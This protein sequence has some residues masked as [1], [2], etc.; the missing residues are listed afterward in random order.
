VLRGGQRV[1]VTQEGS[2]NAST[3]GAGRGGNI[4]LEAP[5]VETLNGARVGSVAQ[6]SGAGGNISII[7]PDAFIATGTNGIAD[8]AQNRGSRITAASFFTSTANAGSI[9][10]QAG[11]VELADGA[12]LSSSTSGIGGGGSVSIV[13][14]GPVSLVGARGD[15][16]GSAIKASTEVEADEAGQVTGPRLG[17]AGAITIQAPQLVL[18]DRAEIV[19]NTALAGAGGRIVINVGSLSLENARI[20]SESTASGANAGTA[21]AVEI[22]ATDGVG[23]H[24]SGR[25]SATTVDGEGGSIVL[26]ANRIYIQGG[27]IS[28]ASTGS[29]NAGDVRVTA[30]DEL[31]MTDGALRTSAP[32]SAGGDIEVMVQ[33]RLLMTDSSITAEAGGVTATD[34]GGNIAIDPEYVIM[35]S[36]DLIA[37]A[38][39]GN[40]GNITIQAG[41]FIP[42][43]DSTIDA[44][45]TSGFDGEVLIDSPNEI[46]GSVLPLESPEVVGAVV[47]QSCVPRATEQRSTLTVETRRSAAVAPGDYLPSPAPEGQLAAANALP[48]C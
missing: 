30:D 31:V 28:A 4:T 17:N 39:A 10:V 40:G 15:G 46:L 19:G 16:A 27:E 5:V 21:G 33:R 23:L 9:S 29:G 13:A 7:A 18:A 34:S 12:R 26:H 44:S 14:T 8:P 25:I 2:V 41:F 38:N 35:T 20:A 48:A 24:D 11:R 3:S 1:T 42:S 37:R 36:S 47:T 22:T 43:G 45:S 32:I 6:A